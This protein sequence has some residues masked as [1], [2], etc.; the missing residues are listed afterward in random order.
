MTILN[1]REQKKIAL[2]ILIFFD[3]FCKQHNLKYF[4]A[5]GTLLGAVRHN[6][7]IPWDDDI[8][9]WMPREDYTR[10]FQLGIKHQY[11]KLMDMSVD[12]NYGKLFG[13]LN[14][15]RT[16]KEEKLSRKRC[17]NTVCINIDI[18]PMDH[19]PDDQSEQIQ[20]L[21]KVR[22]IETKMS[23]LTYAYGKGR[24]FF[25]TMQKNLGIFIY[26]SME[27]FRI[28]SLSKLKQQHEKLM[29]QVDSRSM[30]IGSFTNTGMDGI[31]NCHAKKYFDESTKLEFEGHEF[32]APQ[33]YH[34]V[35]T[36]LFGDYMTPPP[37]EKRV[38]HH[39]N[40][41]YWISEK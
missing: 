10:L 40:K 4:L 41:C 22:A 28:T 6:G 35:L 37:P 2:D 26:R 13:V 31:R 25:S 29:T 5:Y 15:T 17:K 23:C 39:R 33:G 9:I 20:L 38:T 27:F 8:D 16:I 24:T 21:K 19:L 34:E 11:Y 14:D 12:A 36:Q 18:F 30:T 7:Y 32:S 1:I 3:S